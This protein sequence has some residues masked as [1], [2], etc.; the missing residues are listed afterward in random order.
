VLRRHGDAAALAAG[1]AELVTSLMAAAIAARGRCSLALAGGSTPKALY[2]QL[3]AGSAGAI[4]WSRVHVYFGDERAVPPDSPSSNYRMAAEALLDQ[5]PIPPAQIHR[6]AGELPAAEAAAAYAA[7]IAAALPLDLVLLGMGDD[8]HTA[9]LFPGG[10]ID[11][12][13]A[14]IATTSPVA[15]ASRISLAL[16]TINDAGAVLFLISGAGKAARLA[17]VWRELGG[18]HPTLPA[19]C[20]RPGRGSLYWLVDRDAAAEL[21]AE[22]A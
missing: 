13:A 16:H 1:A 5:V 6:I 9:S 14:V 15:P 18:D 12:D 3:A 10:A 4:D 21:P 20:V 8:G 17:E 19:A 7:E 11:G 22:G 2:R